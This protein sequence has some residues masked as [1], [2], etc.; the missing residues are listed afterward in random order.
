MPTCATSRRSPIR[1][2]GR[3]LIALLDDCFDCMVRPMT[4]RGG[5][6]LK[7][8]GDGLLAIFRTRRPAAGGDLRRG[9]GGGQRGA[10]PDGRCWP[11][12]RRR[13]ASRRPASTSRCMSARCS[14]A[15]SAP[16]R[17]STSR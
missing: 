11:P 16:R 1:L 17:G 7:F 6:V 14:T 2:P 15:M 4:R 10:R 13:P 5:E 3:E 9:S 8:L 12:P